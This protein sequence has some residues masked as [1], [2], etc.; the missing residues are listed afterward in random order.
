MRDLVLISSRHQRYEDGSPV[1]GMQ[2]CGRMITITHHDFRDMFKNLNVSPSEGFMVEMFNTDVNDFDGKY[3]TM[4]QP[5]LMRIMSDEPNKI[6]LRGVKLNAMGITCADFSDYSI[7]LHLISR[8]VD[9]CVLH[10]LDRNI[11]I[12]YMDID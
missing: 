12:E 3:P 1:M 6:E 9:K 5:K 11:D 10:M 7:T 4:M 2:Y 8:K